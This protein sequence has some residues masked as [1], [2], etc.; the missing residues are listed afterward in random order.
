MGLQ[1]ALLRKGPLASSGGQAGGFLRTSSEL[2]RPDVMVIFLPFSS[3]NYRTGL[4]PFAGFT[5]S[6]LAMRPESRGTVRVRSAK[7]ED[8]PVIQPNYLAADKDLQTLIHGL[9]AVRRI[10]STD[11]LR[12]EIE[13]E[14]RPGPGV[15][16]GEAFTSYVRAT[17]GS[18]FHPVGT[19][20]MGPGADAV[21]DARLRVHGLTG[22]VVADA[23][24]M[25]SIVSGPT[26]AA[27]IMIGEKASDF[28]LEHH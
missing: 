2:D 28:L 10:V 19:C 25:P 9:Q 1:Y 17:A 26:N 22:L 24:I 6:V 7:W 14:E 13:I 8:A 5:V 27:S 4:D 15:Q 3:N 21:V 12:Q 16:S 23:S 18:V 20:R 11:P